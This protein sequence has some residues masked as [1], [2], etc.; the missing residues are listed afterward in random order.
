MHHI[1]SASCKV[2]ASSSFAE[3]NCGTPGAFSANHLLTRVRLVVRWPSFNNKVHTC[4]V[5]GNDFVL[6]AR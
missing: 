1:A 5:R 2:G 3:A 6:L 4:T